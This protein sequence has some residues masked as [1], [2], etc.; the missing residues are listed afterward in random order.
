MRFLT[1]LLPDYYHKDGQAMLPVRWM[2]PESIH[3]G[4]FSVQSDIWSFGVV[5][6]EVWTY[7]CLP[8]A[9]QT[10][11]EVIYHEWLATMR[12]DARPGCRGMRRSAGAG[13]ARGLPRRS[14]QADERRSSCMQLR[15]PSYAFWQCWHVLPSERIAF[16]SLGTELADIT[17]RLQ[18][19]PN[20]LDLRSGE[21]AVDPLLMSTADL[22]NTHVCICFI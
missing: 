8:Y 7:A 11:Q 3:Q 22:R 20:D 1:I 10:N 2:P 9:A 17:M 6:W 12:A 16:S 19:S 15:V 5:M 14:V 21:V 4:R 18:H 13:A